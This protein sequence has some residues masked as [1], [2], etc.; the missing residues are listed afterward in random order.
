VEVEQLIVSKTDGNPLFIEEL[1][2]SLIES[3]V[4]TQTPEGY[5]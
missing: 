3:G 4:L 5:R 2:R 1:L